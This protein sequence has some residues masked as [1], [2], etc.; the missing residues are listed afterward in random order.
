MLKI[1][2]YRAFLLKIKAENSFWKAS[3][4]S[5]AEWSVGNEWKVSSEE[6]NV[7]KRYIEKGSEHAAL[8][9]YKRIKEHFLH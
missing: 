8:F 9:S 6:K 3:A 1:K 4:V 2:Y 5:L 7:G